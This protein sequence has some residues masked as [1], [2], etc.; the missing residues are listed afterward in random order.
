VSEFQREAMLMISGKP[1]IR[2]IVL[3]L[4]GIATPDVCPVRAQM[5]MP[6]GGRSLGGYGAP[7]ISSYYSGGSS[8][9][10]PY[11]GNAHGFIPYRGESGSGGGLGAQP[12]PRRLSQTSVGGAMMAQTPIGGASLASGMGSGVSMG[13]RSGRSRALLMPFGYEGGIGMG[14]MAPMTGGMGARPT[15]TPTGPGFGYPF[16]MPMSLGGSSS[17]SMP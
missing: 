16:R 5:A 4:A 13:A 12:I 14:G 11:S 10:I 17:M 1:A 15:A 7:A 9:Y 2:A 8:T 6:G 3:L